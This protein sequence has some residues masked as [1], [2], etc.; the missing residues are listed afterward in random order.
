M[1]PPPNVVVP[2]PVKLTEPVAIKFVVLMESSATI[3]PASMFPL[4]PSWV[5][6]VLVPIPTKPVPLE[7]MKDGVAVP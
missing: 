7:T 4:I 1:T 3:M 6:G 5:P 2:V